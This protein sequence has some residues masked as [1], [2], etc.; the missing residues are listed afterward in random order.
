MNH[1]KAVR[2][3]RGKGKPIWFWLVKY[4]Y[5]DQTKSMFVDRCKGQ[6]FR[7][8]RQTILSFFGADDAAAARWSK[9]LHHLFLFM[10]VATS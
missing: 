2:T 10:S 4:L 6:R 7:G 9:L 5:P 3:L 1:L 8:N